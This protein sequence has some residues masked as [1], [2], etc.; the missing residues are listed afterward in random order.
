MIKDMLQRRYKLLFE[1]LGTCVLLSCPILSSQKEEQAV[2]V[3]VTEEVYRTDEVAYITE[4]QL[5]MLYSCSPEEINDTCL[6]ISVE[7]AE[8]LM[9]VAVLEDCTD[10][11]SQAYVMSII[12]NRVESPDFPNTVREVVEQKGQFL[13]LTD[14]RYLNANPD[15]NSHLALAKIESREI[16]TDFLFYEAQWVKNSWASKHRKDPFEYGGSRFYK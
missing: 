4:K 3:K 14:K 15:V 2:P 1:I 13:K 12:M 16:E 7:D 6:V 5:E 9:K 8:I 10:E 11:I